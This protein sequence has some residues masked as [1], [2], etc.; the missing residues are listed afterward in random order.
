[1][2]QYWLIMAQT[3]ALQ[4]YKQ[5]ETAMIKW[6]Q[7]SVDAFCVKIGHQSFD[8]EVICVEPG[9]KEEKHLIGRLRKYGN[10]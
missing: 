2:K 3:R 10:S 9:R 7:T 1:M 8:D 6:K 5:K 4:F